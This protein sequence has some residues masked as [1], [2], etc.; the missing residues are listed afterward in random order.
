MDNAQV[1][2]CLPGKLSLRNV[3]DDH[4]DGSDGAADNT[5]AAEDYNP[6]FSFEI[7]QGAEA[8]QCALL[9]DLWRR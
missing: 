7:S 4:D 5:E 9:R 3:Y 1:L 8:S 6:P 2:L